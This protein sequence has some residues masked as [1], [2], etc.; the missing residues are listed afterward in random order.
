MK[1]SCTG[2]RYHQMGGDNFFGM[3]TYFEHRGKEKREITDPDIYEN[4][5]DFFMLAL[6]CCECSKKTTI[7]ESEL[8]SADVGDERIICHPCKEKIIRESID[9]V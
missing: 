9:S 4:G 5:C 2:C 1:K 3:C 6:L 8:Y 7:K